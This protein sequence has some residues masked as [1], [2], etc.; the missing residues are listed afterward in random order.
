MARSV[1]AASASI[2][3]L[4]S[5]PPSS[6]CNDLG[7]CRTKWSVIWSC[8]TT[9]FA[10]IWVANHSDIP[11]IYDGSWEF[12]LRR[13]F[14]MFMALGAPET[15][16]LFALRQRVAAGRLERQYK[17]RGWTRTHGFFAIMGGYMLYDENDIPVRTLRPK[18]L[19]DDTLD[20][21]NMTQDEIQDRSKGDM[22]S[23]G[24]VLLQTTWF[25]LQCLGR[26][27][28]RLPTTELEITTLALAV[29]NIGTYALWWDKPLNVLRPVRVY[30]KGHRPDYKREEVGPDPLHVGG[31]EESSLLTPKVPETSPTSPPSRDKE[32]SLAPGLER[33]ESYTPPSRDRPISSQ[34]PRTERV[35]RSLPAIDVSTKTFFETVKAYM[36]RAGT[37]YSNSASE[38]RVPTF[39]VGDDDTPGD[40][41]SFFDVLARADY[42]MILG[43]LGVA[44]VFGAIHFIA[45]SFHFPTHTEQILWRI[46]SIATICIPVISIPFFERS[47]P[48]GATHKPPRRKRKV[49]LTLGGYGVYLVYYHC[50]L[51]LLIESFVSLRSLPAGAYQTVEWTT[52]IPHI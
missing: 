50:R 41:N 15:I 29:L 20:F 33:E 3:L 28:E 6:S 36:T 17:K 25:V 19:D 45:W 52:F 32:E 43:M 27:V 46:S 10:C 14:K 2:E 11:D 44:V 1:P 23:K 42:L 5:L 51:F 37:V 48:Q 9:L 22:L 38:T 12:F 34:T 47:P 49:F 24:L 4:T 31:G 39:Y 40:P 21:P 35:P 13:S 26:A 8:L 30:E 16:L 18:A 7:H